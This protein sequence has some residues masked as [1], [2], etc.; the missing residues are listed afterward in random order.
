MGL[1]VHCWSERGSGVKVKYLTG[2]ATADLVV[3]EM[4]DIL[5]N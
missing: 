3:K 2:H 1:L 5:N 4:L